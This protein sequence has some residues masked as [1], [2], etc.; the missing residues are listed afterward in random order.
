M[1]ASQILATAA[2]GE[3]KYAQAF[4]SFGPERRGATVISY[5]RISEA[6]I[7]IRNPIEQPDVAVVLDVGLLKAL[8]PLGR[9]KEGGVALI[10]TAKPPD[11]INRSL[12][13]KGI[14]LYAVDAT[15]VAEKHYGPS[16]LPKT[17]IAMLGAIAYLGRVIRMESLL[18]VIDSYFGGTDAARA[19]EIIQL[20]YKTTYRIHE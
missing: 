5:T 3:G 13:Q 20:A 8:D 2:F 10:N 1:T 12:S 17:N 9:I 11:E 4:P 15:G 7:E 16:S 19:K 14:D 6:P 18:T